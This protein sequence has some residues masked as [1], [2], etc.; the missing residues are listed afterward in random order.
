M[1]SNKSDRLAWRGEKMTSR[2]SGG[3]QMSNMYLV[4]FREVGLVEVVF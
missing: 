4:D 2:W 1:Y 3:L